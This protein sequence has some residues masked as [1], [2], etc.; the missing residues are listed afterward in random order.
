MNFIVETLVD[1]GLDSLKLAPLIAKSEGQVLLIPVHELHH[2]VGLLTVL[3][4]HRK[5]ELEQG[6]SESI[7]LRLRSRRTFIVEPVPR[8]KWM[9]VYIGSLLL[10][11]I[12]IANN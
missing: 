7:A 8:S 6:N 3:L 9:G 2:L 5:P 4:L 12:E 11:V 1:F 10:L